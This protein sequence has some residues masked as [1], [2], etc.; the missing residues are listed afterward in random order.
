MQGER[1]SDVAH[2]QTHS[3]SQYAVLVPQEEHQVHEADVPRVQQVLP[4]PE[5]V[6]TGLRVH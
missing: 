6:L 1:G 5:H 4:G 3:G 2:R